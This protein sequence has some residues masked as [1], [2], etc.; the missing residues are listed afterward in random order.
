MPPSPRT[1]PP[2]STP[3]E[4]AVTPWRH[5]LHT[6]IQESDTPAG[7]AF[8]VALIAA[9][10]FSVALVIA[11][12]VSAVNTPLRRTLYIA[13]WVLTILFT[14]EYIGRLLAVRRP[15][16]YALS[17]YGIV[18][19]LSILPAYL[20]IFIPGAQSLLAIRVLRL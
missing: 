7:R 6:I 17:F 8:D 10:L 14:I 4:P 9:I 12:S 1:S 13:E 15:L 18:D 11:E 3:L 16:K 5:R 2:E 19:L 20:S